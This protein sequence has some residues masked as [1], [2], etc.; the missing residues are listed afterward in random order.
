[1]AL[2]SSALAVP[3]LR[4]FQVAAKGKE[5]EKRGKRWCRNLLLFPLS[6]R[7]FAAAAAVT[8][9]CCTALS[10]QTA[11]SGIRAHERRQDTPTR[12]AGWSR[13]PVVQLSLS[14]PRSPV[15]LTEIPLLAVAWGNQGS[16]SFAAACEQRSFFRAKGHSQLFVQEEKKRA[17]DLAE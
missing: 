12:T 8:A 9:V 11:L 14:I 16:G 13:V 3:R 1:M 7:I 6:C 2:F 4:S 17:Q 5:R 15:L 10:M